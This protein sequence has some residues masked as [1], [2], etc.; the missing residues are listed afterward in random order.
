M[1]DSIHRPSDGLTGAYT[2]HDLGFKIFI[3]TLLSITLDNA[4]ELIILVFM[5]FKPYKGLYFWNL[6]LSSS[7]GLIRTLNLT[8]N[9]ESEASEVAGKL[10]DV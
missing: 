1:T 5:T 9:G 2:G 6:L 7:I 10:R 3:A 4:F 8:G